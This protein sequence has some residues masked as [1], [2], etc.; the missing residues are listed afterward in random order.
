MVMMMMIFIMMMTMMMVMM[1]KVMM[2]MTMTTEMTT[3]K[4]TMRV[5]ILLMRMILRMVIGGEA[6]AVVVHGVVARYPTKA[7][8]SSRI[9]RSR[10]AMFFSSLGWGE[11]SE[12]KRDRSVFGFLLCWG[13]IVN[14]TAFGNNSSSR[15]SMGLLNTVDPLHMLPDFWSTKPWE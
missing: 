11:F 4:M 6:A 3:M 14:V 10:L 12:L 8:S 5:M 13:P 1:V 7:L 2:V 15:L 9:R